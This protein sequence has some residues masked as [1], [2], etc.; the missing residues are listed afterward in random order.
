[1]ADAKT[2]RLIASAIIVETTDRKGF[3][4]IV[5]GRRGMSRVQQFFAGRVSTKVLQIG[6]KHHVWIVN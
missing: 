4:T 3:D 2:K 5:V 1:M 6:Q